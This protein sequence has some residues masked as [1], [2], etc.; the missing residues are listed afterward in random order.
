MVGGKGVEE[1]MQIK[2]TEMGGRFKEVMG[3]EGRRLET[4]DKRV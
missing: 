1:S 3:I 4:G 2:G